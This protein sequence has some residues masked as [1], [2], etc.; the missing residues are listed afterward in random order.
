MYL[1]GGLAS[2]DDRGELDR[3]LPVNSALPDRIKEAIEEVQKH[4][5]DIARRGPVGGDKVCSVDGFPRI[6]LLIRVSTTPDGHGQAE[7][8]A[9]RN[10]G[11]SGATHA[12]DIQQRADGHGSKDL[13]EPVQEA[14]Q[15][16]RTDVEVG[17][18]DAVGL[19]SVEP[20]RRPEHGKQQDDKGL[21]KESIPQTDDF[22]NPAG[23][24][25]QD[26]ARSVG[27]NNIVG[28]TETKTKDG[29]EE[30]QDDEGNVGPIAHGDGAFLAVG[31]LSQGDLSRSRLATRLAREESQTGTDQTPDTGANIED[32]PEPRPVSALL[33][34]SGVGHHYGTLGRPEQAS[35]DT[36]ENPSENVESI[37]VSVERHQQT[38]GV[39]A[40]SQP[41]KGNGE[42]HAETIDNATGHEANDCKGTVEGDILWKTSGPCQ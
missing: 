5:T 6:L 23:V 41:T 33:G 29:T 16:A 27:T 26:D 34:F 1:R 12:V 20:V 17:R 13:S 28:I 19:V 24:L 38:D 25:H 40:V 32:T 8:H 35:A 30:H 4:G 31:C 39:D 9:Q 3:N 2:A 22:G 14:V 21:G 37:S 7:E 42:T 11:T 18:V 15:G 10:A 36:E